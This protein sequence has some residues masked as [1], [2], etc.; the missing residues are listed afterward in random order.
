MIETYKIL[1]LILIPF[2]KAVYNS[3]KFSLLFIYYIV[4]KH[5]LLHFI[6]YP[7]KENEIKI[8]K[9]IYKDYKKLKRMIK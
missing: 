1:K 4:F 2:F 8:N 9:I 5:L 3:I 7:C 6:L